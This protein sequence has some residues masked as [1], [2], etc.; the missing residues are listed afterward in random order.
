[1]S[2]QLTTIT[3][4]HYKGWRHKIWAFTQMG[5]APARIKNT[6]GLQFFKL[7]GSGAGK[8]FSIRPDFSTY[9]F[10]GV[11][12]SR[13]YAALFFDASPAY[14]RFE[15]HS[16]EQ[17][18]IFLQATKV[19]GQWNKTQPFD[20]VPANPDLPIAVLTR[21]SINRNRLWEFW[22][23]V[24]ENEKSIAQAKGLIFSK[25]V[26]E[27]PLVEQATVSIWESK[28]AMFQFAYKNEIHR[29]TIQKTHARNWYSEEMF[30][31]FQVIDK[32]GLLF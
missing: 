2:T 1:M 9:C 10:L 16:T 6:P 12:E 27:L 20:I 13:N 28:E 3:F 21:A 22:Q 5:L 31:E 17:K 23:H 25:G 8:G 19:K 7:M 26:G 29:N 11:W 14:Q 32:K 18:T 4:F 24:P 30:A 15:N